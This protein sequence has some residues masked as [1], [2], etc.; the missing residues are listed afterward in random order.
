MAHHI[1]PAGHR[2]RHPW[3]YSSSPR[4][5]DRHLSPTG[6]LI[7]SREE[8]TFLWVVVWAA[9]GW[10]VVVEQVMGEQSPPPGFLGAPIGGSDQGHRSEGRDL[11]KPV[12][13][14]PWPGAD[15][16]QFG[17]W[18]TP[19]IRMAS[20]AHCHLQIKEETLAIVGDLSLH[21]S[22]LTCTTCNIP[23]DNTC[24]AM[25]SR[26]Y[27][28]QHFINIFGP[29]CGSCCKGF[30]LDEDVRIVDGETFHLACFTCQVCSVPLEKGMQVGRA[31]S[32]G[33]LCEEH[34]LQVKEEEEQAEK[35][36]TEA[37]SINQFPESP[38]SDENEESDKE[39]EEKNEKKECKDG[40]RRG[41][42]TNITAKQLEMLKNVFNSN[43]KPTRLMREQLAKDTSLSMR[44]I[45]VWFQ[46][47]RSKEKRMH[48][49]RYAGGYQ[50]G[51][52]HHH[53]MFQPSNNI[54]YNYSQAAYYGG[55]TEQEYYTMQGQGEMEHSRTFHPY[56]SPPPQHSDFP[57][58]H[59][60]ADPPC[61]PSPPLSECQEYHDMISY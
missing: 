50:A 27:C 10:W 46:N 43:P 38:K 58:H 26:L 33:V 36:E 55:Y 20:C 57:T 8:N 17:Y 23:L 53:G 59:S 45:Q 48:Q 54:S 24:F 19:V 14:R 3:T 6:V 30:D 15:K 12:G 44:V 1:N 29:K 47:K 9:G 21:E 34:F 5:S 49:L 39:N 2:S 32:G 13:H 16:N 42:R 51:P 22:C 4:G 28:K 41:P 18:E 56:P 25:Q 52:L 61:F 37:S 11:G 31:L 60:H 35:V 7:E 40:K